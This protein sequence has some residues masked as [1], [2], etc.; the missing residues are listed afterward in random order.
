[1]NPA[2]GTQAWFAAY[3]AAFN[4]SDFAGFG[5]FYHDDVQFHGQAA[6]VSGRDAVLAFYRHAWARL[7]ERVD[8][9]SFVGSAT[10]CAAELRTTISARED[11]PDF[12]TGA[13]TAGERRSSIAFAFYDI[14]A[15]RFTRIRSARFK[16]LTPHIID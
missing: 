14:E 1:V 3:L 15:G 7:D 5:A 4:A 9:L 12:P 10:V 13:L 11:W 8:L 16:S 6:R 2:V